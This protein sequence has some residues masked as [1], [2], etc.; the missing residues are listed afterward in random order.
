MTDK[1]FEDFG[2]FSWVETK[3][4]VCHLCGSVER[5]LGNNYDQELTVINEKLKDIAALKAENAEMKDLP[6]KSSSSRNHTI[7]SNSPLLQ[8]IAEI[9]AKIKEQQMTSSVRKLLQIQ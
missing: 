4:N 8:R 6:P 7:K 5:S 3:S 2:E 9:K 1:M